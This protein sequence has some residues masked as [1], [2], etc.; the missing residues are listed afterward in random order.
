MAKTTTKSRR[1]EVRRNM[2]RTRPTLREVMLRRQVFV[3]VG[4][5][6]AFIVVAGLL[7]IYAHDEPRY[8]PGQLVDRGLVTRVSLEWVDETGTDIKRQTVRDQT[9]SVYYANEDFFTRLRQRLMALPEA[10][11]YADVSE[12]AGP[13][14][15]QFSLT[16][17]TL[18]ELR[19]FATEG[20]PTAEWSKLV[21]RF[22]DDLY[23]TPI[24]ISKRYQLEQYGQAVEVVL[25]VPGQ[26]ARTTGNASLV[27][28]ADKDT[29]VRRVTAIAARFPQAIRAGVA[30]YVAQI[31]QP[32]FLINEQE[33]KAAK[34]AAAADVR[35][36]RVYA[37][38]EQIIAAGQTISRDYYE[39]LKVE[40]NR[41]L[42]SLTPVNRWV[43]LLSPLLLIVLLAAGLV[44]CVLAMQPRIAENP[45]RGLALTLLLLGSLT[46][47][48]LIRS[49]W[50]YT[51]GIGAT[52]GALLATVIV[53]I[54]YN[55]RFAMA[56]AV[57]Q[58][59]LIAVV[60]ELP[61]G[62]MLAVLAGCVVAV[63]QL[64][65]VRQ[66]FALIRMGAV[67][68]LVIAVGVFAALLSG[69]QMVEGLYKA[70][71]TEALWAL[72]GAT[73]VGFFVLGVLPFIERAFKVTTAMTLLELG[74][75]N[76][77][78]LKRL[79][80]QA[81]GT[82]NHSLTLATIAEGAAEAIGA[83]GLLARVGAYFHDCG[84][85]NKP[86]YFIE[87]QAGGPN[88]HA[89]LSPAM[90]LLIIVGHVKDG[91]EMAREYHLP[92]VINHFIES[93]HG[94]TLVEY[95]F[96]AAKKRQNEDDQPSEIE[97]RYPGPKPR[98]RETAILLL[99]DSVEAAIRTMPDPNPRRIEQFV[100]QMAMKRLMDG[101]FADSPITLAELST[102]EE[103]IT[104]SL[105]GIYHGRIA[106][107]KDQD[108]AP[109]A[110][111]SAPA[112]DRAAG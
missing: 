93:H 35:V 94:T 100:H 57:L 45:L 52:C 16:N 92:P 51:Q 36:M 112:T 30:A 98:T 1:E 62:L 103:A 37:Q 8:R 48:W 81:P 72:A 43:Y 28:L 4:L 53:A 96:H 42:A 95:F 99:C 44:G 87:N 69:A 29:V 91:I 49:P 15:K 17:A 105:C 80:Q 13:L 34:D 39:L 104:K 55:Q 102:I 97:F 46:L 31:G 33:T 14:V 9:P 106:Y 22:M 41:Y 56:I 64:R 76:H 10:S 101:Q 78:L 77:P 27:D 2:P 20:Q 90:S 11:K 54:A 68:G 32:T 73:V 18:A 74:D 59:L 6:A 65:E 71:A 111:E 3:G 75:M 63:A 67:S 60:L 50:P 85:L 82:F 66:R 21:G 23:W 89:K 19:Q 47:A 86:E 58:C 83:N 24:L 84:K 109:E 70:V 108:Q 12:V 5:T 88:K 7:A 40:R 61:A 79:A 25:N 110:S 107:P 26:P 38:G